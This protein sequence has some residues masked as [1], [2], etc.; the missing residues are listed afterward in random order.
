M[1]GS[2]FFIEALRKPVDQLTRAQRFIRRSWQLGSFAYGQLTRHRAE[3]MAAELTYRTIFSLIPVV[4]LG[5][6]MFRVFGGLEKVQTQVEDQLYS[7][8]GVPVIPDAWSEP[9]PTDPADPTRVVVEGSEVTDTASPDTSAVSE[10]ANDTEREVTQSAAGIDRDQD[11]A[12]APPPGIAAPPG[13]A[14]ETEV[15]TD[16]VKAE[17]QRTRD[18]IRQTLRDVTAKVTSLDFTSIGVFGLLVFIYAAY[19][20][21]DAVEQAFNRIFNAPNGRPI[22]LK[23]AIYWSTGTL[24]SGLLALSLYMSGVVVQRFGDYG[25]TSG[26]V[27][28]SHSLSIV[29]SWVLLF[30][31]YALMPNTHVSLRAAATAALVGSFL[32]EAAKYGFQLYVNNFL[33]YKALY[34]SIGLI[35]L[36]LFWVYIT[37]LIILFG[38]ILAHSIQ[39]F[40][41]RPEALVEPV[42]RD[43]PEG[44]PDWMVPIMVEINRRYSEGEPVDEGQ[45]ADQ[46]GLTSTAVHDLVRRLV[47]AGLVRRVIHGAGDDESLVPGRPADAITMEELL[48]LAHGSAPGNE[49]PGWRILERMKDAEREIVA[50]QTLADLKV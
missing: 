4:V 14:S 23:V 46:L 37:W 20:L 42:R 10:V 39:T 5:L 40:R 35:P 7:F 19:T 8:F 34:G 44:D 18:V 27:L 21:A 13:S 48:K 38:L 1:P 31:L 36:F 2:A 28:L 25:G 32:W 43:L 24:G 3:G 26:E 12:T 6:V 11:P 16:D 22:H 30:L 29:A 45:V 49:H 33:P 17:Q 41:T 47:K 9:I 15:A 50:G